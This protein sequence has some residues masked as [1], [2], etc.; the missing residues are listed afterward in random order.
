M[1]CRSIFEY[2][3]RISPRAPTPQTSPLRHSKYSRPLRTQSSPSVSFPL[4]P[5]AVNV[6]QL[7][8]SPLFPPLARAFLLSPFVT[9]SCVS[10]G[11]G[12]PQ[13]W[14]TDSTASRASAPPLTPCVY[15]TYRQVIANHLYNQHLRIPRGWGSPQL[16]NRK[17]RLL[18]LLRKTKAASTSRVLNSSR[19]ASIPVVGARL[20]LHSSLPLVIPALHRPARRRQ[21]TQE[22][23]QTHE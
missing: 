5:S 1:C 7:L 21:S 17:S 19:P 14:L 16:F 22:E 8:L 18:F 11:R 12:V 23:Q 13:L 4:R 2:S 9:D 20:Q 15:N 3:R 6:Q 10:T